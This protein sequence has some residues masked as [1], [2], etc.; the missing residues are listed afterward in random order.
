MV[1]GDTLRKLGLSPVRV[2]LGE[3]ELEEDGL[4]DVQ[5]REMDHALQ[6][7]GFERIGDRKGRLIERVKQ[8]V[9]AL[10]H[11]Q[12]GPEQPLKYS[13]LIAE[14]VGEE[15]DYLNRLFS[16]VEGVT[17]GQYLILQKIEKVKELL[18]YGDR[19]LTEIAAEMGYSSVA[20]LSAQFRKVTG[21]T[22]THFRQ[23][24]DQKRQALDQVG[25]PG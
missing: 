11:S 13:A 3:V 21:L 1:V 5:L 9:I 24:R 14:A 18:V 25:K 22:P 4:S 10:V 2:E 17:V 7:L 6:Q 8:V 20:H 12:N 23:V 15:Y 16:E 19:T